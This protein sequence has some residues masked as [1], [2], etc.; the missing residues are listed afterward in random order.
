MSRAY[1]Q[2]AMLSAPV[3]TR[4]ADH[5][6]GGVVVPAERQRGDQWLAQTT[7]TSLV[8]TWLLGP[9]SHARRPLAEQ[10][11]RYGTVGG[12]CTAV[13]SALYLVLA[14]PLGTTVANTV[15]MI[16]SAVLNTALNRRHTFRATRQ[17]RAVQHHAQGTVI[18]VL[19][20]L[21]STGSLWGLRILAPAAAHIVELIVLTCAN[22]GGTLMR[23]I[24]LKM[25]VFRPSAE[26]ATG[27]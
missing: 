3:L 12:V 16:V 19:N 5:R 4:A 25:W 27:S 21:L 7:P 24:L 13:F 8:T 11:M 17:G 15:A 6:T 23:F 10:V 26:S 20:W 14:G 18:M 22:L 2:R 1:H 9:I